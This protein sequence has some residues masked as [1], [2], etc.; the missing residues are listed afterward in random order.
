MVAAA[1]RSSAPVGAPGAR[2]R[3]EDAQNLMARLFGSAPG[4]SPPRRGL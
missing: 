2:T 4:V 3:S 1:G